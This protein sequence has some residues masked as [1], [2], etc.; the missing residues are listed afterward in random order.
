MQFLFL[1]FRAYVPNVRKTIH[2]KNLKKNF[3]IGLQTASRGSSGAL[4][5]TM[6]AF[7]EGILP[8]KDIQAIYKTGK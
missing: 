2:S 3:H 4:N 5:L 8:E 6:L 1:C 7:W